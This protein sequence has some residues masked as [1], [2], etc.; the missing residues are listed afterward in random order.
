MRSSSIRRRRIVY[1]GGPPYPSAPTCTAICLSAYLPTLEESSARVSTEVGYVQTQCKVAIARAPKVTSLRDSYL[2]DF[3][4]TFGKN[5]TFAVGARHVEIG[6]TSKEFFSL[7]V[8]NRTNESSRIR[9]RQ[10]LKS[11]LGVESTLARYACAI[12]VAAHA[13]TPFAYSALWNKCVFI[14]VA[15]A[16]AA[17]AQLLKRSTAR[18]APPPPP[19]PPPL[20]P[21]SLP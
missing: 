16:A 18:A 1:C 17:A 19:P 15:A 14:A 3:R 11:W 8:A 6:G 20:L 5:I 2:L 9:S 4:S 21:C 13:R 12:A 10:R 7:H